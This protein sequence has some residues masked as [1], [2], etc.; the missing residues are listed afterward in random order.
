MSQASLSKS[1]SPYLCEFKTQAQAESLVAE[2]G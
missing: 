1:L 2:L